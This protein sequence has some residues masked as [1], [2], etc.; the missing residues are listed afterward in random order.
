MEFASE[1]SVHIVG[2][3]NV[4]KPTV[5]VFPKLLTCIDCGFTEFRMPE[6]ELR[7]LTKGPASDVEAAG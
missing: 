3:E 1:I 7:L 5:M 6:K 4:D 2:L